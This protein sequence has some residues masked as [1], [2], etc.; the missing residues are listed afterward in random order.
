MTPSGSS[1]FANQDRCQQQRSL[2]QEP[3]QAPPSPE[4]A[5][6]QPGEQPTFSLSSAVNGAN[7]SLTAIPRLYA[8]NDK[9]ENLRHITQRSLRE[10]LQEA[11][12]I[13]EDDDDMEF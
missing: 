13:L 5:R 10:I 2:H 7:F 8:V 11:L 4:Q 1:S 9:P 3:Q 12:D 6:P